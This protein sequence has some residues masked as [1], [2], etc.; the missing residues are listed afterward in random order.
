MDRLRRGDHS[1]TAFTDDE[2]HWQV[3]TAYTRTGLAEGEKVLIILD[4]HDLSDDEVVA[5]MDC[6]SGR[7]EAAWDSGQLVLTRSPS[8]F[9]FPGGRFDKQRH[10]E[11]FEREIELAREEGWS[12]LRNAGDMG[13][14]LEQ[15]L[16]DDEVVDYETSVEALFADGRF[17]AICWYDQRRFSDYLVAA[18]SEVHPL[19]VLERLDAIDVVRTTKGGRIAGAAELPTREKFTEALRMAL[20]RPGSRGPFHFELDLTDLTFMEAHCAWQLISFAGSLPE[21]SKVV[22]SCGPLVELSLR[23]LGVDT[24]PQLELRVEEFQ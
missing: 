4:P 13:W 24:V 16:S 18:A 3:L 1:C 14:V 22:V 20:E 19:Q 11:I 10:A 12:G 6:G 23:G 5:R 9:D 7:V 8:F 2:A 15:G 17:T 21:G